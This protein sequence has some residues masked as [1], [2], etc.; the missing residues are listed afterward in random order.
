MT[1]FAARSSLSPFRFLL[2]SS[3][4]F[5]VAQEADKLPWHQWDGSEKQQ[6]LIKRLCEK[7]Y[8][9]FYGV[10]IT[11]I[12]RRCSSNQQIAFEINWTTFTTNPHIEHNLDEAWVMSKWVTSASIAKQ[13]KIHFLSLRRLRCRRWCN[14]PRISL[15]NTPTSE[16]SYQ[17]GNRS[18]S[19]L[20][21]RASTTTRCNS[22]PAIC[23]CDIAREL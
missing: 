9:V 23:V 22:K 13:S 14:E 10:F 4:P 12:R 3:T 19:D 21:K 18:A 2:S 1:R 11:S 6:R 15:G 20:C 5:P 17:S 8:F 7:N 16:D